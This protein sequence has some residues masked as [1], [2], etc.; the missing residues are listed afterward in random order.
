MAADRD[1]NQLR[2]FVSIL[3]LLVELETCFDFSNPLIYKL[4]DGLF[5]CLGVYWL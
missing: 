1:V 3:A 2:R 5:F 4:E